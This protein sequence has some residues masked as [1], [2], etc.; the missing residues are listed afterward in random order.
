MIELQEQIFIPDCLNEL[1]DRLSIRERQLIK[2][3]AMGYTNIEVSLVVGI[4]PTT[5]KIHRSS[6]YKKMG[7]SSLKDLM[8]LLEVKPAY[9]LD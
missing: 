5:V 2:Y 6:A 3:F 1:L 8:R 4:A 7:V 9:A